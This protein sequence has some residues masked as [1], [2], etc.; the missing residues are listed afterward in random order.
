MFIKKR[1][2]LLLMLLGLWQV[3]TGS[4]TILVYS[5]LKKG[6][7]QRI[8]EI[9]NSTLF[10]AKY[11]ALFALINIFGTIFILF[12]LL[13]LLISKQCI[14]QNKYSNKICAWL[15]FQSVFLYLCMDLIGA[16]LATIV[17]IL[18]L[19][20]RKVLKKIRSYN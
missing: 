3:V 16:I 11:G 10:Q 4:I 18:Y 15:V 13:N 1:E 19:A 6:N 5:F 20:K 14:H 9:G 7:M 12:G 2:S 17:T 8:I